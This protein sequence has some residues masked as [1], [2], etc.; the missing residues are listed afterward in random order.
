MKIYCFSKFVIDNQTNKANKSDPSFHCNYNLISMYMFYYEST[1]VLEPFMFAFWLN[2]SMNY[3]AY[4]CYV[5]NYRIKKPFPLWLF[6]I[7]VQ[8]YESITY[9][10]SLA[11]FLMQMHGL[12]PLV[13][14]CHIFSNFETLYILLI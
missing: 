5:S 10:E 8:I 6:A 9:K 2:M 1:L 4:I 3:N 7:R 14:D 12:L 13:W 11:L